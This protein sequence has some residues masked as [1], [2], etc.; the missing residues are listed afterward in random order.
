M[1]FPKTEPSNG[2]TLWAQTPPHPHSSCRRAPMCAGWSPSRRRTAAP[3]ALDGPR[4]PPSALPASVEVG[5]AAVETPC[6]TSSCAAAAQELP[7]APGGGREPGRGAGRWRA[8]TPRRELGGESKWE[9]E[10]EEEEE[11]NKRGSRQSSKKEQEKQLWTS[12]PLLLALA[13]NS[14]LVHPPPPL[15]NEN[16]FLSLVLL[17]LCLLPSPAV[18]PHP[19][20]GRCWSVMLRMLLSFP[21]DPLS[22]LEEKRSSECQNVSGS[23]ETGGRIW[24]EGKRRKGDDPLKHMHPQRNSRDCDEMECKCMESGHHVWTANVAETC[25]YLCKWYFGSADFPVFPPW[26][27]R[28]S[29]SLPHF[30]RAPLKPTKMMTFS[31]SLSRNHMA[32]GPIRFKKKRSNKKNLKTTF[33]GFKQQSFFFFADVLRVVPL[34]LSLSVIRHQNVGR[35]ASKGPHSFSNKS[36]NWNPQKKTNV[37]LFI[38]SAKGLSIILQQPDA[39]SKCEQKHLKYSRV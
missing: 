21:F 19:Q 35:E 18:F 9:E 24:K 4:T 30:V 12:P 16:L 17:S 2:L 1:R 25:S 36:C 31:H 23:V 34:F 20:R 11:R 13:A 28:N 22:L 7:A 5:K 33:E 29:N 14:P 32:K 38:F 3:P 39:K 27:M 10:Q 8:E 6:E 37:Y 26:F 15:H